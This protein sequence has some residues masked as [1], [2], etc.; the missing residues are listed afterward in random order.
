MGKHALDQ[1][2]YVAFLLLIGELL[3]QRQLF[4][5]LLKPLPVQLRVQYLLG[6][7]VVKAKGKN[8]MHGDFSRTASCHRY[9]LLFLG[10]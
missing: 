7:A 8:N 10:P 3:I 4:C 2:P 6:A 5:Q 1:F 9:S